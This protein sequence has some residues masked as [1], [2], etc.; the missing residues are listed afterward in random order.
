MNELTFDIDLSSSVPMYEQIYNYIKNEIKAGRIPCGYRL[1]STRALAEYIDVSRSTTQMAYDQLLSE[2]YIESVPCRGYFVCQLDGLYDFAEV[3]PVS[4]AASPNTVS[5]YDYDFSPRGIALDN[6][7]FNAW[8]KV[9]RNV[10]TDDNLALFNNGAPEGEFGLKNTIC[11]YLHQS[12]GVICSPDRIII[13]AGN[14][15]LL[16]L[17]NLLISK[18]SVFAMENPTYSQAYKTLKNSGRDIIPIS[19]D[20]DGINIRNLRESNADVAYV[21]PSHQFPMGIV[22]PLRRRQELLKW[23]NESPNRYII[24]DD[25]DSE[26]RYKGKPI[27][28]LQ[29]SAGT[30]EHVIYLGTFSKAIAP[31]IRMS[32]MVLPSKLYEI[33]Q[34]SYSFLSNTVSRIDQ[35]I[36]NAFMQDGYYERHLNKLRALYKTRH[37]ILLNELKSFENKFTIHGEYSGIHILLTSK[38]NASEDSL[39]LLAQEERVRVYPISSYCIDGTEN[40]FKQPATILI[41]YANISSDDIINGIS[42]LRRAWL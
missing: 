2:G 35:N 40:D 5:L 22:M 12:R 34:S 15:Y 14:E 10:L 39:V 8:R 6:F 21:M 37:D 19:M 4:S 31:A 7:P 23:A 25:Y 13:G 11:E 32:Y 38:T 26:F 42:A 20:K 1:P 30:S 41:G 33:Y 18:T 27:P 3:K 29:G 24:E 17:L 9:T 16:M 28:S 36:V